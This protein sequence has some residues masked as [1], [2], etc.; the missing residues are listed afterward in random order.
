M[1]E[2]LLDSIDL[3]A[4]LGIT[5][6]SISDRLYRNPGS[7]PPAIKIGSLNRWKPADVERWIDEQRERSIQEQ[8]E[9]A[10]AVKGLDRGKRERATAGKQIT[11]VSLTSSAVGKESV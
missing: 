8:Q 10:E 7:L 3:G 5:V 6:K 2:Q 1:P 4:W 11:R 9:R